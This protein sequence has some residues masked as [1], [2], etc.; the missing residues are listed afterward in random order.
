[1]EAE[2]RAAYGRALGASERFGEAA[3]QLRAAA[4]LARTAGEVE[5]RAACLADLARARFHLGDF[6]RTVAACREALLLPGVGDDPDRAWTFLNIVAAAQL[7]KGEYAAAVE[8]SARA[9]EGREQAGDRRAVA[10][11]L[12]NIGV[13]HMYLGDHD[14]A[15]EFLQRARSLKAELGD[16]AGVADMLANIGDIKHL[17]GLDEEAI[18]IQREALALRRAEGGERGIALSLRSLA[19][20]LQGAGRHREALE[21]AEEALAINRRLGLE[22]EIVT[23]LA[24]RAEALAA[25]GRADEAVPAAEESVELARRLDMRGREVMALDALIVALASA[26]DADAALEH[27]A[28]ARRLER[29]LA[30]EEVRSEFAALR[31]GFETRDKEREIELLRRDNELQALALRHQRLWRNSLVVGIALVLILAGIGWHRVLGNRRE[32]RLRREADAAMLRSM[33]RYRQLFERNLSGVFQTDLDGTILIVN[34]TFAAMLD[35]PDP[36]E[37]AGWSIYSLAADPEACRRGLATLALGREP[38][39]FETTLVTRTGKQVSVLMNA[40]RVPG[41]GGGAEIIE[42]IAVDISDRNRAEEDRRRLEEELQQSRKLESLGVLAG[43]IAHDFNNML[44]AILSNI[45]LAKR[46]A[47]GSAGAPPRGGGDPPRPD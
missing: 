44:M 36:D 47:T 41:N 23:A 42:G 40:G 20:A 17:Q 7:Q 12:N 37:L 46:Q 6:D 24:I 5:L 2:V 10:I 31:A 8:T 14:Q 39:T 34:R 26:G 25:L 4:D 43:G 21:R 11:L 32:S 1:V 16:A 38:R 13:A 29:E 19:A 30:N 18:A 9:L 22:P 28:E 15:L 45:S 35:H 33:E 27:L 3:D